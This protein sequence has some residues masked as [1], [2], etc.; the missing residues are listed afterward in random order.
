[1]TGQIAANAMQNGLYMAAWYDTLVIAPPLII[2]EEEIDHALEI[3]NRSLEI[4]DRETVSTGISASRSSEF[5][6]PE[7]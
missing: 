1:M 4:G 5:S 2:T 7:A 3:L 6:R